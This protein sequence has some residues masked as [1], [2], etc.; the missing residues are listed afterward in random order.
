MLCLTVVDEPYPLVTASCSSTSRSFMTCVSSSRQFSSLHVVIGAYVPSMCPAGPVASPSL[1]T[2]GS[3]VP[4]G[5]VTMFYALRGARRR[6]N[7]GYPAPVQRLHALDRK[8]Y[9]SY[10][11]TAEIREPVLRPVVP[12]NGH[13]QGQRWSNRILKLHRAAYRTGSATLANS[14]GKARGN[15]RSVRSHG[16]P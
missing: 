3:G 10:A 2:G 16:H 12:G 7:P 4:T 8:T 11:K 1:T 13:F 15:W 6:V 9:R 14:G 5:T